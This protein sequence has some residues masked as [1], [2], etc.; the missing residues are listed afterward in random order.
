MKDPFHD[1]EVVNSPISSNSQYIIRKL[2]V[3]LEVVVL[4]FEISRE[5]GYILSVSGK[6][7]SIRFFRG[8]RGIRFFVWRVLKIR[9][10]FFCRGILLLNFCFL[11]STNGGF[12]QRSFFAQG[13]SQRGFSL[14]IF[15]GGRIFL[16]PL[17]VTNIFVL[18]WAINSIITF[19]GRS[20]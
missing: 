17:R 3:K 20:R 19:R 1:P 8:F 15:A 13:L 9:N 10:Q 6:V 5:F 18:W 12:H 7:R 2:S 11:R 14:N 4:K 16:F